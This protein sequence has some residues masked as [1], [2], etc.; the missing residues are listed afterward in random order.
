MVVC[1]NC[2]G[3]TGFEGMKRPMR[4]AETW[5]CEGPGKVTGEG[6]ASVAVNG[7]V[8]KGSCKEVEPWN[9]EGSL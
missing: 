3:G 6:A 5:N 8:L 2:S 9:H 4:A 1:K 7:P